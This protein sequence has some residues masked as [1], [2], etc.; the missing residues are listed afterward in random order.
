MFPAGES[1]GCVRR[2]GDRLQPTCEGLRVMKTYNRRRSRAVTRMFIFY[3]SLPIIKEGRGGL[4]DEASERV[5]DV[6]L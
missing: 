5:N 3:S 2:G 4:N 1:K 6:Q